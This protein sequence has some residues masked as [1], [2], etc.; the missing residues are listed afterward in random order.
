MIFNQSITH[1]HSGFIDKS[2]TIKGPNDGKYC[3]QHNYI[4]LL[5]SYK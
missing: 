3:E 1:I 5:D 2:K 4:T